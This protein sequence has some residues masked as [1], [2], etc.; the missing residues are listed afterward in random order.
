MGFGMRTLLVAI[1]FTMTSF[2]CGAGG[3]DVAQSR[4]DSVA[5]VTV[6]AIL[7]CSTDG[8]YILFQCADGSTGKQN[9]AFDRYADKHVCRA[10]NGVVTCD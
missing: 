10:S 8:K 6:E 5:C 7:G 2:S 9:C 1:V 3:S 4:D